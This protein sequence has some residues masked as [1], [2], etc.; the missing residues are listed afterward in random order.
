[1]MDELEKGRACVE[2]HSK[3]V[4]ELSRKIWSKC[5][6]KEVRRIAAQ[7]DCPDPELDRKKWDELPEMVGDH[8]RT[9]AAQAILTAKNQPPETD[10]A[11][12]LISLF[13]ELEHL[14]P[15]SL[16][17]ASHGIVWDAD[18]ERLVLL[19][20]VGDAV[21][22]HPLNPGDLT[23][24]PISTAASLAAKVAEELAKDDSEMILFKR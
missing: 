12:Y 21:Y 6:C 16:S 4:E 10:Q 1:M 7:C 19:I 14:K 3:Q 9:M 20:N 13:R 8:V 24:D 2:G 23:G 5:N 17:V 15:T 22:L 11:Q 18:W